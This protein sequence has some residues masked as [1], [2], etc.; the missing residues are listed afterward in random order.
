MATQIDYNTQIKNTPT[1][2]EIP[3][4]VASDYEW[5]FTPPTNLT[6][7]AGVESTATFT[8]LPAG[9]T[10]A[11]SPNKHYVGVD[12][13]GGHG[14]YLITAVSDAAKTI[15]FTPDQSHAATTWTLRSASGGIQEAVYANVGDFIY[16]PMG[17]ILYDAKKVWVNR[18]NVTIRGAGKKATILEFTYPGADG[19]WSDTYGYE[20]HDMRFEPTG[21][22]TQTAGAVISL[23]GTTPKYQGEADVTVTGCEFYNMYNG[24]VYDC[25]GG[26]IRVL[27][28]MVRGMVNYAVYHKSSVAGALQ[29]CDNYMDG[30]E[31]PGLIWLEQVTSGVIIADNWMQAAKT[32]I[33]INST[34]TAA[35]FGV[36]EVVITGNILDNDRLNT[37]ASV[38]VGGSGVE[39]TS[40]NSVQIVANY[41]SSVGFCVLVQNGYNVFIKANKLFARYTNPIIAVAGT[42]ANNI[43]ISD[44]E[45]WAGPSY[46]ISYAIQLSA[47]TITN[48]TIMSN[49]ASASSVCA[50]MIGIASA[51]TGLQIVGNVCGQNF[52]KLIA[53]VATTGAG[54]VQ[55]KGNVATNQPYVGTTHTGALTIPLVDESQYIG[56]AAST[57][58]I[59][60]MNGVTARAGNN[61]N[62]I[63]GAAQVWGTSTTT[64]GC[65]GKAYSAAAAGELVT[66]HKFSD[67]LWYPTK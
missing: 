11:T 59:T 22:A 33:V 62:F 67:N 3:A 6:L 28:N 4:V 14:S 2:P 32:H 52:L 17:T 37:V 9:L 45:F 66:F 24:I 38:I 26:F 39:L 58:T 27:D 53:D 54:Q 20:I 7:V 15:K 25:P 48:C 16:V 31:S 12:V 36:Y 40:S 51:V 47:T 49:K 35:S 29:I 41:F 43:T 61:V 56:V 5:S 57:A 1:L 46:V 18:A 19:F 65:I 21:T 55:C 34:N 64:D 10:E 13:A 63:T 50:A 30:V 44:N 23:V 8:A 42:S 60:T